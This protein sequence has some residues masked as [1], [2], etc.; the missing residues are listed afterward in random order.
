MRPSC[1][2]TLVGAAFQVAV[3]DISPPLISMASDQLQL[4]SD[5]LRLHEGAIKRPAVQ[6]LF[7][8]LLLT[9]FCIGD[10]AVIG[11]GVY[12]GERGVRRGHAVL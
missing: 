10:S 6:A 9:P 12:H 11:Y 3:R 7:A 2:T 4:P 5:R 1:L 8:K